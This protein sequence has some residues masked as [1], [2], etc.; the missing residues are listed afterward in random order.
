MTHPEAREPALDIDLMA[1]VDG[2]LDPDRR[3]EVEARLAR[4]ADARE[5]V[6]QLRHFDNMIHAAARAADSQPANLRIAALERQLAARLQRRRWRSALTAP[7]ARQAAAS[8]AIFAAG[9]AAHGAY[10]AGTAYP[11][12][13]QPTLTGHQSHVLAAHERGAFGGDEMAEAL[14]WLSEQMQRKIDSPKLERLG[15]RVESARLMMVDDA[16]VAVFYYRNPE[17]ERVTVSMTPRQPSQPSYALRVAKVNDDSM[18]Y[19]TH[20]QLHYVVLASPGHRLPIT[21]LAAAVTD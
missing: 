2:T 10:E 11:S 1:Y 17:E 5:A 13:V 8:V 21:T 15:Y 6:A 19:W 12:F 4:D 18:A 9:W 14:A 7:W 16:P 3:A 20:D